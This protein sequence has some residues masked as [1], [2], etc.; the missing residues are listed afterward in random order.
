MAL[1]F[2]DIFFGAILAMIARGGDDDGDKPTSN[3][4]PK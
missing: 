1:T 3:T 2:Y 4:H